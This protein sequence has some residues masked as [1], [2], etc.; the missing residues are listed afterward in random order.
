[1][2]F[3]KKHFKEYFAKDAII[4]EKEFFSQQKDII[5]NFNAN[6]FFKFSP[7]IFSLSIAIPILV[8]IGYK[9]IHI[10]LLNVT[11]LKILF[12][13]AIAYL[14]ILTLGFCFKNFVKQYS[15]YILDTLFLL[16]YIEVIAINFTL[17]APTPYVLLLGLRVMFPMLEI[18]YRWRINLTNN[19]V[20]TI[21]VFV[22]SYIFKP[23]DVFFIDFFTSIMFTLLASIVGG[24]T[25]TNHIQYIE[26]HETKIDAELELERARNEAKNKF[27]SHMSHEVRTP[28]NSILGLNEMILR[29]AH[30]QRIIDYA[31][32]IKSSGEMLLKLIND[33][34]DYSRIEVG[35][36]KITPVE[37]EL[38][39]LLSEIINMM[40]PKAQ[41]KNL[42]FKTQIDEEIPH[43]LY[44]DELRIKQCITNIINNAIKYT[45]KGSVTLAASYKRIDD[46][47]I[48]L[49]IKIIDTG[50]GIKEED[51]PHL[52]KAFERLDETRNR[53]IEGTGLGMNIVQML[54][55]KMESK[56][57]V[58]SEYG[59]GSEFS[60][61]IKQR[62][63]WWE[64]IG[65][66]DERYYRALEKRTVYQETFHA[67][68]ARILIV[69]D[70]KMNLIVIEGLLKP[71]KIQIDTA[72]SG[73]EMLDLAQKRAYDI[74]FIDYRMPIMDGIE[75]LHNLR[76]LNNNLNKGVPCIALTA[77]VIAEAREIYLKE[78]FSDYLAKPVDP[79]LLEKMIHDYLPQSKIMDI[80]PIKDT[81]QIQNESQQ[82]TEPIMG[83][84]L[85]NIKGIDFNTGI[86]NCG[87]TE[88]LLAAL[89]EYHSSIQNK[90]NLIEHYA[91][92]KD[93]K[94]YTIQVHALKSASLMIGAKE[95][96]EMAAHMEACGDKQDSVEIENKT[97]ELLALYRSYLDKL[98][99][100]SEA[101][102]EYL[103]PVE[104]AKTF[105]FNAI[106]SIIEMI[107]GYSIPDELSEQYQE[108]KR[109][110]RA[111]DS[112]ALL[113]LLEK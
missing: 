33:I 47:H 55:D 49:T 77:N 100:V 84:E 16:I 92:E 7:L 38:T 108:I 61:T 81:I 21:A 57:D 46:G 8:L 2:E 69:D 19:L 62:V 39:Y 11:Q 14:I 97:P 76:K 23:F 20:I 56:L 12:P 15:I 80:V 112:D 89:K 93:Y 3:L 99:V 65:N 27:L 32:D 29:E 101:Q 71:T 64:R 6:I 4:T 70:T 9:I 86:Q 34:L 60:F 31:N 111:G 109:L 22:L 50:I 113:K 68:N 59:K 105:D 13:F 42:E 78:G 43:L 53:T 24:M 102:A 10:P 54:L 17:P 26:A 110:V 74:I 106:D 104:F 95:L 79:K 90:A 103:P 63:V 30:S 75:A 94:N 98:K 67:P 5:K 87:D 83:K 1:M 58:K 73:A 107:D 82:E 52:F 40:A 41:E 18:D 35:K 25:L 37:Y 45:E 91:K 48:N 72:M 51:L 85:A 28:L 88:V 44:G 66:I 36:V 96:G